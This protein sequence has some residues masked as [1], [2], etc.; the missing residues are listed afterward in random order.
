MKSLQVTQNKMLRVLNGTQI[1][2][3]I[4]TVSLLE[5]FGLLSVN[6]LAAKIKLLKGWKIVN[7]NDYPLSL[8]PYSHQRKNQEHNL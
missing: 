8:E 3:K 1:K 5:K 4:S 7:N 6:Q 2:D